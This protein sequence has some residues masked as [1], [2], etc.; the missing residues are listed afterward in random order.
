MPRDSGGRSLKVA[1]LSGGDTASTPALTHIFNRRK[2]WLHLCSQAG[3]NL[4]GYGGHVTRVS[5]FVQ[6]N[7]PSKH[8]D[9]AVGRA[10][11][12]RRRELSKKGKGGVHDGEGS[13]DEAGRPGVHPTPTG[14]DTPGT[15][16]AR[17]SRGVL[18]E[19][20]GVW[21]EPN[22]IDEEEKEDAQ[23]DE[24]ENGSWSGPLKTFRT[25][26][27]WKSLRRLHTCSG[28]VSGEAIEEWE[29]GRRVRRRP[30]G[31][32]YKRRY[33]E[34]LERGDQDDQGQAAG[35]VEGPRDQGSEERT[36]SEGQE[37]EEKIIQDG[38]G[39][40]SNS[41]K[42]PWDEGEGSEEEQG[43]EKEGEV[44]QRPRRGG[45][46]GRGDRGLPEWLQQQGLS[47]EETEKTTPPLERMSLKRAGSVLK[48][49]V[50]HMSE[51]LENL[52]GGASSHGGSVAAGV[53]GVKYWHLVLKPLL[54]TKT[55]GRCTACFKP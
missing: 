12:Q 42:G 6:E 47:Q 49:F 31:G 34:E 35:S 53:S 33:F 51:S 27:W 2:Q 46:P 32:G 19:Q 41:S 24:E 23:Q 3:C 36:R 39:S 43:I 40:G 14:R 18:E 29:T 38:Y 44:S 17:Q 15:H 13:E 5:H 22:E 28:E 54:G 7:Y 4:E 25:E 26:A 16:R 37:G 11:Q 52:D 55:P 45:V 30:F 10:L 1:C 21:T 8:L 9:P 48:M 50:E 20:E